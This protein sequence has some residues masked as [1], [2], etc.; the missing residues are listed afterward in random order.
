MTNLVTFQRLGEMGRASETRSG[1]TII[2][3]SQD[4]V[5]NGE[6]YVDIDFGGLRFVNPPVVTFGGVVDSL[7]TSIPHVEADVVLPWA[8]IVREDQLASYISGMRLYIRVTGDFTQRSA[9]MWMAVG[10]AVRF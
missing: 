10:D 6:T 2:Y 3:G 1:T 9:L 5:G 8:A 4:L 7:G